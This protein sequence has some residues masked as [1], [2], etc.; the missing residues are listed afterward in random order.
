MPTINESEGTIAPANRLCSALDL[1]EIT[2]HQSNGI[3]PDLVR[4]YE[5]IQAWCW[6]PNLYQCIEQMFK[7]MIGKSSK[8]GNYPGGHLLYD[9]FQLLSNDH[10]SNLR[11][12]FESFLLIHEEIDVNDLDVFL[13]QI[14]LGKK[15][16]PGYVSWRYFLL[17]G[18]PQDRNLIAV[19]S[20][21][22]MFEI[23]RMCSE[24]IQR[25]F[26]LQQAPRPLE[27]LQARM[28]RKLYEAFAGATHREDPPYLSQEDI[29]NEKL[30]TGRSFSQITVDVEQYLWDVLRKNMGYILMNLRDDLGGIFPTEQDRTIYFQTLLNHLSERDR[31]WIGR[32]V[33][34]L[35]KDKQDFVKYFSSILTG[36][37][38]IVEATYS[39]DPNA[40]GYHVT[41]KYK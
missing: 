10:Q 31:I 8:N 15:N 41:L 27:P 24:I 18:F 5:G 3:Q 23:A 13:K 17:E 32:V 40:K 33:R 9:L 14:D 36:E 2:W 35:K 22:A 28:G 29:E 1:L 20:V 16:E 37:V 6:I 38:K 30:K 12:C 11:N 39:I 25:E 21:D 4:E 19:Q 26:I 7:L 34:S